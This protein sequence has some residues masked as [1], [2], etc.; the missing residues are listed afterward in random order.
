MEFDPDAYLAEKDDSFDPDAYLSERGEDQS[1]GDKAI[2]AASETLRV[3]GLAARSFAEGGVSLPLVAA[4]L[5]A[6]PINAISRAMTGND[7]IFNYQEQF[8]KGMDELGL[9]QARNEGEQL[10]AAT[11]RGV[12]AVASGIGAGQLMAGSANATTQGVGNILQTTPGIQAI[13]G[14]SA[15]GGG[16]LV[17]QEG[18]SETEQLLAAL[19][20]GITP[21]A[22]TASVAPKLAPLMERAGFKAGANLLKPIP[23]NAIPLPEGAVTSRAAVATPEKIKVVTESGAQKVG[24]NPENLSDDLTALIEKNAKQALEAGSDLTPDAVARMSVY[25]S[26]GIKPTRALITRSFDDALQEQNLLTEPE[27]QALRNIYIENNRAIRNQINSTVDNGK[28]VDAPSFGQEVRG[29]LQANERRAQQVVNKEFNK[30]MEI[31]GDMPTQTQPLVDYLQNNAIYLADNKYG[32]PI[33]TKLKQLGVISQ[34]N[35]VALEPTPQS[36]AGGLG[37]NA[38]PVTLKELATVRQEVNRAWKSAKSNQD[39]GAAAKLNDMRSIL[40][41]IEANAGSN[42]Y[43]AYRKLRTQKGARYEDNP[44]IDNLL[45]D[46]RGYV[47]TKQI[48]DSQVFDT[49]V[50]KST[51]E[52]FEKM[53]PRLTPQ[54]RELTRAQVVKYIDDEVF[55]NMGTNEAADVVASA[56][57]LNRVLDRIN[58]NKLRVIF[59]K[60]K[61]EKL[62]QLNTAVREISNPP[63]GTVPTGSAP[64]LQ[65]LTRSIVGLMSSTAK[66]P[67]VN[68]AASA[69]ASGLESGAKSRAAKATSD[70]AI[71][72]IPKVSTQPKANNLPPLLA[73][74]LEQEQAR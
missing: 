44:L 29:K 60:E 34:D 7:A 33:I 65:M 42:M 59:G 23:E 38:L 10:L 26:L 71:N 12:G 70:S 8:S 50:L 61:A 39:G 4:D 54:A 14:A 6:M 28:P 64:K 67:L 56:A 13:S 40:N 22:L 25:E 53:W 24:L 3:A 9:P 35:M 1:L 73:P 46:K 43:K 27:G 49:A 63:K 57:K 41:N 30:A 18:G 21:A 11:G 52:Q 48:E 69:I 36:P 55:S 72:I 37:F 15:G 19:A 31:E 58:P 20:A 62:E 74:I 5:A 66:I 45:K 32:K 2:D 17:R 47:G 51:T 16:E 68:D